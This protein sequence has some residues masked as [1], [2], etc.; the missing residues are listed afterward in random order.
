[1]NFLCLFSENIRQRSRRNLLRVKLS[2]SKH[3][4]VFFFLSQECSRFVTIPSCLLMLICKL[5]PEKAGGFFQLN[6]KVSSVL[7]EV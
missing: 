1:M 3:R 5:H 2:D 4:Y 7:L 6:I